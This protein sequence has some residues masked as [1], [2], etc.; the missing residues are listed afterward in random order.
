MLTSEEKG[1]LASSR[2]GLGEGW[3]R[4]AFEPLFSQYATSSAKTTH[5]LLEITD[6]PTQVPTEEHAIHQIP[7]HGAYDS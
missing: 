5:N 4:V 7:R 3:M 2:K 1:K 6:T